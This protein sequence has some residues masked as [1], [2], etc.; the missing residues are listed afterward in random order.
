MLIGRV[1]LVSEWS[2]E[3]TMK[4]TTITCIA[5]VEEGKTINYLRITLLGHKIT[6][7]H[8]LKDV[9]LTEELVKTIS[10]EWSVEEY[11]LGR[12]V[13]AARVEE[14]RHRLVTAHSGERPCKSVSTEV[15]RA[16]H[17]S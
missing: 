5:A 14:L 15:S 7:A 6:V 4:Q 3:N 17:Y 11:S 10:A 2:V 16:S 1:V 8:L 13:S 12:Y 9:E